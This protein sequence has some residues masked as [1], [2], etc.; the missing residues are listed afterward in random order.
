MLQNKPVGLSFKESLKA[1]MGKT[2]RNAVRAIIFVDD[3]IM[4]MYR[5][6][7]DRIYY[8]FPGGGKNKMKAKKI[9]L[10]ERLRKSLALM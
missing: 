5:E 4:S 1:Q 10:S 9:V 3:K 7:N 2:K 8:T 6:K